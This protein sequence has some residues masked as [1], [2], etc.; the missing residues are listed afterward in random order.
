[1]RDIFKNSLLVLCIAVSSVT[2][3]AQY[4]AQA[5]QYMFVPEVFNPASVSANNRY[6]VL[7]LY[8]LQWLDM[9][10]GP[11]TLFF[12][13]NAPLRFLKHDHGVGIMFENDNAGMFST[14]TVDLQYAFKYQIKKSVLS[15]GLNLGFINQGINS[16][17][18]NMLEGTDEYHQG[19]DPKV[20]TSSVNAVA[21]DV[22]VGALYRANEYYV[23]ISAYHLTAPSFDLD[24]NVSTKISPVMYFTGGYTY[25]LPNGRY[26]IIADVMLKTDFAAY[27][28]DF[29]AR[30]EVEELYYLGIGWKVQDAVTIFGGVSLYNGLSIGYSFDLATTKLISRT[31][32]SHELFL[33]YS[34]LIGGK[35]N[36]RYKSVRIL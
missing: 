21:F 35:K 20:A 1:M 10:G 19:S 8:R 13:A 18:I 3:K 24:D 9:D 31:Y 30:F 11:Q 28:I 14:Q 27:Q 2:T 34:F 5:S 26:A 33:R 4:E 16:D 7:G 6:N 22:G 29:D 23:G 17:S 12:T 32:G 15:F 36:N 25:G